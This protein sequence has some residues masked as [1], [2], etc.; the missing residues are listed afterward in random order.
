MKPHPRST[1]A[2]LCIS[3]IAAAS[4]LFPPRTLAQGSLTPPGAPAPTMKTLD[5]VE[6]RTPISGTTTISASGSYYLT[7][8]IAVTTGSAISISADNV[9]LDLN[10]FTISSTASPASGNGVNITG[11]RSHVTVKNG[12]IRGTTTFAAG[13]FTPGGFLSGIINSVITSTNFHVSEV[14]V[15]GV[16]NSGIDFLLA[17]SDPRNVVEHCSVSVCSTVGIR[18]GR[19]RFCDVD[20][21]GTDAI[22]ADSAAYCFG[23]SVGTTV[24]DD[25]IVA[26]ASADNCV[27]I[28]IAG[29]G[30]NASDAAS[31]CSGTSTSNVGLSA[32]VAQN[33]VGSSTSNV[34]LSVV[35]SATN[36]SGTSSSSIGL[37][38]NLATNSTGTS[39]T[40][41][42][43]LQVPG[44]ASFCRG[45]RD[46]G[47]AISA[48][49]AIGCT[50]TGSGTITS[51]N[52]FLGTP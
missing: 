31:N 40:G 3:A 38:G 5:Q 8:N 35:E 4:F 9:T 15:S 41:S 12:N 49:I 50:V 39:T 24:N 42:F 52:K 27:G 46:G 25:G 17:T 21:A 32:R 26:F 34:G 47:V 51:A 2:A 48:T 1:F 28:A 16:A 37:S 22:L 6:A 18:A 23:Q 30:L 19:V 29:R 20:T 33:C 14:K 45:R 44:A 10:G 43:G 13:T 36:C 11:S 7:G